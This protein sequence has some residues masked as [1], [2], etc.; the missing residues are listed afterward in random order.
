M[1]KDRP[2]QGRT[3]QGRTGQGRAGQKGIMNNRIEKDY[4][5]GAK[6]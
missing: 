1:I 5:N 6:S 2:G 4:C 3:G